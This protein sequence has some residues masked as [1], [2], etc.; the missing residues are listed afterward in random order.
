MG[1]K[2]ICAFLVMYCTDGVPYE[3]HL[4]VEQQNRNI[5]IPMVLMNLRSDGTFGFPGGKLEKGENL[6]QGIAREVM[7]EIAYEIDIKKLKP[8][9]NFDKDDKKIY[10][11]KYEVN[12][13]T[14]LNIRNN[15]VNATHSLGEVSGYNLIHCINY[16][17]NKGFQSFIN[18]NF[19]ETSRSELIMLLNEVG[20][21]EL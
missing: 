16:A 4:D 11:F 5:K 20:V 9:A 12:F 2:L 7:E 15:A 17:E 8:L 3:K 21:L 18:N 14:L 1:N 6:R 19:C 13:K 10:T